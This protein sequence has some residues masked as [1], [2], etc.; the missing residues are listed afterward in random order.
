[1]ESSL[2]VW[3]IAV[4]AASIVITALIVLMIVALVGRYCYRVK[5]TR[6]QYYV[7]SPGE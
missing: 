3:V 2:P 5:Q 1:M 6:K 7:S 4:I